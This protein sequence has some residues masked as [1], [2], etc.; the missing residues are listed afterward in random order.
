MAI[1][2]EDLNLH[3]LGDVEDFSSEVPTDQLPSV[4][5]VR[6]HAHMTKSRGGSRS[7]RKWVWVTAVTLL[8]VVGVVIAIAVPVSKNRSIPQGNAIVNP[9]KLEQTIHQIALN[10]KDDFENES[11]YHSHA[12]RW[13]MEDNLLQNQEYTYDQLK[14]RYAM[15]SLY[16]A[17]GASSA[18]QVS[19][20]WKRKGVPECD[21][22]G[23]MCDIDTQ[24]VTR[25]E[26]RNNGLT[27]TT[28]PE[29]SLIETLQV[30]NL[31]ANSLTGSMPPHVC[32]LT[33]FEGSDGR[34][35]EVKV[36]CAT[37][38]CDCCVNCIVVDTEDDPDR[39]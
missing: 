15:F 3:E 8:V 6:M 16:H 28:P 29:V 23:V 1:M 13:L 18:W 21:W 36:D 7:N 31:N 9:R 35:L 27:G 32:Q 11:S 26:L 12:K 17:T 37:V 5:E 4:E 20:G 19:N 10:G 38:E 22:Y 33:E 30:L 39:N 25:I 24:L 2:Q 34:T 14:Q